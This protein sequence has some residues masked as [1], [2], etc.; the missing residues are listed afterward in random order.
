MTTIYYN[1][2]R[3]TCSITEFPQLVWF[4]CPKIWWKFD[5]RTIRKL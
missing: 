5:V 4:K 3:E 2:L 1:I